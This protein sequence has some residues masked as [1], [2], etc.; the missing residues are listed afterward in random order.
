M[1]YIL[2]GLS[3]VW[4]FMYK[5]EWLIDSKTFLINIGYSVVLFIA[6]YLLLEYGVGNPKTIVALRMPLISSIVFLALFQLF[7]LIFKR[8]PRNTFFVFK[9][10]A[11]EDVVF[12]I[13][14]WV[15]GGGVPFFIVM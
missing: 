9:R 4:L 15:I 12:S 13:L 5:I 7:K 8:N 14:F 10:E 3:T 11:I 6:S 1:G 2:I